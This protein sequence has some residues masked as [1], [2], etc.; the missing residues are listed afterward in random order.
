MQAVMRPLSDLLS[1]PAVGRGAPARARRFRP[2]PGKGLLVPTV[3]FEVDGHLAGRAT[4]RILD[5]VLR[6]LAFAL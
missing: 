2:L 3:S 1:D 6:G 4:A 5:Q